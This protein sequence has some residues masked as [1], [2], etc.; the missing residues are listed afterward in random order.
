M[1]T[2]VAP[3][4]DRRR[5][6]SDVSAAAA[7]ERHGIGRPRGVLVAVAAALVVLSTQPASAD[8]KPV[9]SA[10]QFHVRGQCYPCSTCPVY[11][12]VRRPCTPDSDTLC[13]PLYDF[14]FVAGMQPDGGHSRRRTNSSQPLL[15]A[16]SSPSSDAVNIDSGSSFVTYTKWRC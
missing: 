1:S 16:P 15:R 8:A 13:G 3:S 5:G 10:G 4:V 2:T 9:C 11:L 12:I 7:L 14:E 6:E